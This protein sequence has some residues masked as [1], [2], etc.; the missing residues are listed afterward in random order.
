MAVGNS[1]SIP[2]S[3]VHE[4]AEFVGSPLR[5]HLMDARCPQVLTGALI[6]LTGRSPAPRRMPQPE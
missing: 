2:S 4:V 5:P 1:T 6:T 3:G